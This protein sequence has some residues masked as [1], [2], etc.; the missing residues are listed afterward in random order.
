MIFE[1]FDLVAIVRC[2]S[3]TGE[4]KEYTVGELCPYPFGSE[5]LR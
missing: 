2:Y 3:T 4:Y 5:D 1:L